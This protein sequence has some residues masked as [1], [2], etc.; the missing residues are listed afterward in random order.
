MPTEKQIC[1][2][3]MAIFSIAAIYC[4]YLG[5]KWSKEDNKSKEAVNPLND[6]YFYEVWEQDK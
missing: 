4:L 1:E 3:L 2:M 5:Y 6:K